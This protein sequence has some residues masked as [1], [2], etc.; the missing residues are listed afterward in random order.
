MA[1][2]RP[3]DQPA[4]LDP[5]SAAMGKLLAETW[6]SGM[7]VLPPRDDS[8]PVR[9]P[10]LHKSVLP[11]SLSGQ[12]RVSLAGVGE[13]FAAW[14][15]T[16]QLNAPVIVRIPHVPASEL[17]QDLSH[18]IAALTLIPD[19]VGPDPIAFHDDP[20]LSPI[21]HPYVVTTDVPGA[22]AAPAAWTQHHL[23]AHA[24]LLARLHTIQA[25]G[26]G[27]VSLGADVWAQVPPGPPS[28][29][30]E[31]AEQIA[32]W[33]S[34]HPQVLADQQLE[35]FLEAAHQRVA[36]I[37][38]EIVSLDQFVLA[39][40]D[41]CATNILW[42]PPSD[43]SAAPAVP[44]VR[45]IDFEWAQGDDPARDLAIIG[46]AVHGGPWFVPMGERQVEQFV[47]EYV[48][49]RAE[50]GEVPGSVADTVALR[51]RMRAWTAY[52]RTAMLVHVAIRAA[53]DPSYRSTLATL[54][55]TLAAELE[56]KD[57]AEGP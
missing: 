8:S 51:R 54:R 17:H 31:V 26:R 1:A 10:G 48:T 41:L 49:A 28:L 46:G 55:R 57:G 3:H 43:E 15:V 14:R 44:T 27:P 30:S 13:R 4:R 22:A 11:S 34:Q 18:E 2:H 38:P 40:G 39:H 16:P 21:S 50:H 47:A 36:A 25:T 5:C 20:E 35:P 7:L 52:D 29:L 32:S 37:E 9:L 42:A 12:A 45:Y 56:L 23:S 53:S 6:S 24:A 19:E 33:R